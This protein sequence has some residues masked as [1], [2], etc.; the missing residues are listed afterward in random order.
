MKKRQI[1]LYFVVIP[2]AFVVFWWSYQ[3]SGG[4]IFRPAQYAIGVAG[5]LSG[6]L[7]LYRTRLERKSSG[8]SD[9]E[10]LLKQAGGASALLGQSGTVRMIGWLCV[11]VPVVMLII[12]AMTMPPVRLFIFLLAVLAS[13][14]TPIACVCFQYSSKWR[15]IAEHAGAKVW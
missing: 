11:A 5:L 4:E 7:V 15:R 13:I 9:E 2:I 8:L 6:T 14:C 12:V 10:F 3:R 1:I